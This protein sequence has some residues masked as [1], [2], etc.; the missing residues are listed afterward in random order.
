MSTDLKPLQRT[1]HLI[2]NCN[3]AF[4]YAL[5]GGEALWTVAPLAA[6]DSGMAWLSSTEAAERLRMFRQMHPQTTASLATLH[7]EADPATP[8]D[9]V[10]VSV[11][12]WG[13]PA[14]EE[15]VG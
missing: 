14:A 1:L 6:V 10:C 7:M 13:T 11:R 3:G 8:Q 4:L 9:W 12:A 15:L 5:V 2:S